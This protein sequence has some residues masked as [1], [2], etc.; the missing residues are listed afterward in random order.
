MVNWTLLSM[1]GPATDQIAF[2]PQLPPRLGIE[3][4]PNPERAVPD[5]HRRFG[6]ETA[7]A[8]GWSA[9]S[10]NCASQ[11]DRPTARQLPRRLIARPALDGRQNSLRHQ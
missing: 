4:R 7:S 2:N 11:L 6:K 3:H 8:S 10:A 9:S 5:H 1:M